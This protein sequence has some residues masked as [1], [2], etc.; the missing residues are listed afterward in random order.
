MLYSVGDVEDVGK[1]HLCHAVGT[2]SRHVRHNDA[3]AGGFFRVDDV[4]ARGEDADVFKTGKLQQRIALENNFVGQQN[5]GVV[6]TGDD[7]FV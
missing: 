6:C 7:L 3:A 2:V 5:V 1:R 4:V